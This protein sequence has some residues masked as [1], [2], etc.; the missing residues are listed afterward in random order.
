MKKLIADIKSMIIIIDT[1]LL[2][3]VIS[4][5]IIHLGMNPIK[6]GIPAIDRRFRAKGILFI[7][8]LLEFN[9]LI[10]FSF[11]NLIFIRRISE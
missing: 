2:I 8:W 7:F 4:F 9:I 10:L 11:I 5:K 1:L 3:W 6:G